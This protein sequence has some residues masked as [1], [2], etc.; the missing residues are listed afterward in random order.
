M[1]NFFIKK[2]IQNTKDYEILTKNMELLKLF[3]KYKRDIRN[4]TRF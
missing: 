2:K 1:S 4:I 3:Y